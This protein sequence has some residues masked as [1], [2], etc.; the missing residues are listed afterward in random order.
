MSVVRRQ[1]ILPLAVS[2]RIRMLLIGLCVIPILDLPLRQVPCSVIR[3]LIPVL[4]YARGV[5]GGGIPQLTYLVI[6]VRPV[7]VVLQVCDPRDVVSCIIGISVPG[8]LRAAPFRRGVVRLRQRCGCSAFAPRQGDRCSSSDR[9]RRSW[10]ECTC[11]SS[12]YRCCPSQR[13]TR[14]P[15]RS[16]RPPEG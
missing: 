14:C 15:W 3:I 16:R 7:A 10:R 13:R 12:R 4:C 11:L 2:V 9:Y 6:R 1:Q 5:V 8:Q